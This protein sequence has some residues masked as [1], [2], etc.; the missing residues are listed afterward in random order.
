M[1]EKIYVVNRIRR[2]E[3]FWLLSDEE[4]KNMLEAIAKIREEAGAKE[5]AMLKTCSSDWHFVRVMVFPD[6]E[7]YH[8][9]RMAI[10]PGKLNTERYFDADITLGFEPPTKRMVLAGRGMS[11]DY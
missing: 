11:L 4:R 2:R 7:A 3:A 10:G 9:F 8:K 5:L 1:A 6:M